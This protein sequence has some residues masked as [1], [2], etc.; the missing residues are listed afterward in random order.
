MGI[1]LRLGW[2]F[3]DRNLK[4]NYQLRNFLA[5]KCVAVENCCCLLGF[6]VCLFGFFFLFGGGGGVGVGGCREKKLGPNHCLFLE[7][8]FQLSAYFTQRLQLW[9][10]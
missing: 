9:E 7:G 1:I 3:T 8:R 5:Q 2:N 6:V 10:S 4:S